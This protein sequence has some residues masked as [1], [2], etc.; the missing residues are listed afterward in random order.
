MTT[1]PICLKNFTPDPRKPKQKYCSR[2]CWRQSLFKQV[3]KVCETCGKEFSVYQAAAAQKYCSWEC[4]TRQVQLTCEYCGEPFYVKASHAHK[5]ST[6]SRACKMKLATQQGRHP[7]QGTHR[8]ETT[9]RRVSDGL[10][11]YYS[12]AP[13]RHWNFKGG[14]FSQRRG[15]YSEWREKRQLARERA[16][17]QCEICGKTEAE[18][19]KQLSVHHIK[20]FRLFQSASEANDLNNLICAC[21]SCHMKLEHGSIAVP[22]R[23][24]SPSS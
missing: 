5:R 22:S 2:A 9:R 24:Q 19:G 12:D 23:L 3:T 21:Q 11:R 6:C 14:N 1:C 16:R 7:H 8:D 4:R 20:P 15:T 17:F 18:L 13:E 10:K